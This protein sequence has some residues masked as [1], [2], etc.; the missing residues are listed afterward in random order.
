MWPHRDSP[1]AI[2]GRVANRRPAAHHTATPMSGG[3]A[4]LLR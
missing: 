3:F 4:R 2:T 1:C